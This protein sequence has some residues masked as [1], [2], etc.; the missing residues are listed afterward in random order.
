MT[1]PS[2][3]PAAAIVADAFTQLSG[4]IVETLDIL[5]KDLGREGDQVTWLKD[6]IRTEYQAYIS[7]DVNA[8][9]QV[10]PEL[11]ALEECC[12]S[13]RHFWYETTILSGYED[14]ED[15]VFLR[16][17]ETLIELV[18]FGLVEFCEI[19]GSRIPAALAMGQILTEAYDKIWGESE[20]LAKNQKEWNEL[21][22]D[23]AAAMAELQAVYHHFF[24]VLELHWNA[25]REAVRKGLFATQD[26]LQEALPLIP[27]DGSG[28]A[29]HQSVSGFLASLERLGSE[30]TPYQGGEIYQA[31]A[32]AISDCAKGLSE[33]RRQAGAA[34]TPTGARQSSRGAAGPG[35]SA[36]PAAVAP[37]KA[38]GVSAS[39]GTGAAGQPLD[40]IAG[41][42][43]P[44]ASGPAV[45][46]DNS[47]QADTTA[48]T[49]Y[50]RELVKRIDHNVP[51]GNLRK[52]LDGLLNLIK[53]DAFSSCFDKA[54]LR[55]GFEA[56]DASRRRVGV[57]KG[58]LAGWAKSE[59]RSLERGCRALSALRESLAAFA[60][61]V[62]NILPAAIGLD[63]SL[64]DGIRTFT[65]SSPD[66]QKREA[67]EKQ[68][69]ELAESHTRLMQDARAVY[70]GARAL[71][72]ENVPVPKGMTV[73]TPALGD[74]EYLERAIRDVNAVVTEGLR[75]S[76]LSSV[77]QGFTGTA[78][79][80]WQALKP[81]PPS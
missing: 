44:A 69:K 30:L 7:K 81:K 76:A 59:Q 36:A 8:F 1:K 56:I 23:V 16:H 55:N 18:T 52:G 66:R 63:K 65:G 35:P 42:A 19:L 12:E 22:N 5:K 13:L 38:T 64:A 17:A 60:V 80:L 25:F 15:Q 46:A 39:A 24:Q 79:R 11:A 74:N 43:R 47:R 40:P 61:A 48:L 9:R 67:F 71:A 31:A 70:E 28:G 58:K 54:R 29:F 32:D 62:D 3:A 73:E 72:T 2:T 75:P 37:V 49:I 20:K 68:V 45:R 51:Y 78:R 26:K 77:A 4:S 41:E 53:N 27:Q 6:T 34:V 33:R 50:A 57:A 21:W 14:L 10:D